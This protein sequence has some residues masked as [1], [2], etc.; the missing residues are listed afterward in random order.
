MAS[1][2]CGRGLLGFIKLVVDDVDGMEDER[3][4]DGAEGDQDH[5]HDGHDAR[6]DKALVRRPEAAGGQDEVDRNVAHPRE[7]AY[8]AVVLGRQHDMVGLLQR[9]THLIKPNEPVA[10]VASQAAREQVVS[11]GRA[12]GFETP[13]GAQ[14]ET[15]HQVDT[16]SEQL[17]FQQHPPEHRQVGGTQVEHPREAE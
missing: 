3:T 8:V 6:D 14:L 16:R 9:A 11:V 5:E 17:H 15:R 4:A 1:P 10:L 12:T 13:S 2:A 7:P